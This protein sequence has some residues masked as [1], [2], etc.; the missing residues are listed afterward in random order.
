M[1]YH[2]KEMAGATR[3]SDASGSLHAKLG[4]LMGTV[5]SAF[6]GATGSS[7]A[8]D[9]FGEI[10][11]HAAQQILAG[12]GFSCHPE[13]VFVDVKDNHIFAAVRVD[14]LKHLGHDVGSH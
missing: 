14:Q 9:C 12:E 6:T 4:G 10:I 7:S 11:A 3:T 2:Y 8:G 1:Q 13:A 5:A